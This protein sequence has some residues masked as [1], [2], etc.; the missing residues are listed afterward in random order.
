MRILVDQDGVIAN[1]EQGVINQWTD[2][3]PDRP[4]I[5]IG[6]RVGF[7]VISQYPKRWQQDVRNII[8]SPGFFRQL[9][10]VDGALHALQHMVD[11]GHDVRICTSPLTRFDNCVTEKFHWVNDHLGEDW[12]PRIIVAK[13]KTWVRGDYLIDDK[14]QVDGSQTPTWTHVLYD[15]GIN[16]RQPDGPL[17]ELQLTWDNWT[18]LL[19]TPPATHP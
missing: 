17:P 8:Q 2:R 19:D 12:V 10:P 16:T 9:P 14:P 7:K 5:P 15:T 18:W 11:V 4:H 1:F 6:Q 13:D 3:H